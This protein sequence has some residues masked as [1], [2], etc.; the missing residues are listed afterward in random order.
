L[1]RLA[2]EVIGKPAPPVCPER[3]ACADGRRQGADR[4][5]PAVDSSLE[6]GSDRGGEALENADQNAAG[7]DDMDENPPEIPQVLC[8]VVRREQ[9][10]DGAAIGLVP[11]VNEAACKERIGHGM[12]QSGVGE[13]VS[14]DARQGIKKA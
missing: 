8:V 7:R 9:V 3:L 13:R 2:R 4:E 10:P 1:R 11:E 5:G 12:G 14:D 6:A